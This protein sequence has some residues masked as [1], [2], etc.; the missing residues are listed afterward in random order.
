MKPGGSRLLRLWL[1]TRRH[2]RLSAELPEAQ[3]GDEFRLSRRVS[4]MWTVLFRFRLFF[5]HLI[6]QFYYTR[7]NKVKTIK[8]RLSLNAVPLLSDL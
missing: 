3:P 5:F 7:N 2:T 6:Y 8:A 4:L 1:L